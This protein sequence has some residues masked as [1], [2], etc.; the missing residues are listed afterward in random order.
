MYLKAT[1]PDGEAVDD[2]DYQ[3]GRAGTDRL[4][5]LIRLPAGVNARGCT[6][7]AT[8]YYQSIPPYYLDDRFRDVPGGAAT[9]RLYY[10]TSN[11]N[12]AGTPVENWKLK[13]A[14]ADTPVRRRVVRREAPR[15][16]PRAQSPAVGAARTAQA[17]SRT[18]SG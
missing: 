15:R 12:L 2:P 3:D 17:P 4:T 9:K 1:Q 10:L 11:L 5:Y 18:R 6:V 14:T 16:T 8:L 13:V 7:R